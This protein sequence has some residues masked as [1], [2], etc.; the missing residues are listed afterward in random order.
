MIKHFV[1]AHWLA[2]YPVGTRCQSFQADFGE[3]ITAESLH[4]LL[5]DRRE[6]SRPSSCEDS[7]SLIETLLKDLWNGQRST[8]H[9]TNSR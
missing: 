1:Y 3:H 8:R 9:E 5:G 6:S 4:K 2:G 7:L